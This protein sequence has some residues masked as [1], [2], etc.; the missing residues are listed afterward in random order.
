YVGL[1]HTG[2]QIHDPMG[3]TMEIFKKYFGEIKQALHKLVE[4]EFITEP[5][6][7]QEMLIA[8]SRSKPRSEEEEEESAPAKPKSKAASAKDEEVPARRR[9]A[10]ADDA[11]EDEA[12]VKAKPAAKKRASAK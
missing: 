7:P 10:A 1:G 6:E 5:P 8:P 2:D 4:M 9:K 3:S 11:D 12:E